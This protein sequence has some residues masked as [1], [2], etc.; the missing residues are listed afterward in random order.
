MSRKNNIVLEK[1]ADVSGPDIIRVYKSKGKITGRLTIH[2]FIDSAT[3]QHVYYAPAFNISSYAKDPDDAMEMMKE[4]IID[5]FE[6][7]I[8]LTDDRLKQEL[9]KLGWRQEKFFKKNF[10]HLTVDANG[11]LQG[12]AFNGKVEKFALVA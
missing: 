12:L 2:N 6:F 1:A 9:K 11:E 4:S 8:S 3:Y 10:S 7:L 5:F